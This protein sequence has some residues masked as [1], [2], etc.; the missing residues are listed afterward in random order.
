MYLWPLTV[1]V[2]VALSACVADV[3]TSDSSQPATVKPGG[4]SGNGD[5]CPKT[6]C[7]TNSPFLG[8][9]EFHE[10]EETGT[11]ANAEG[12]RV[13]RMEKLGVPY[14]PHVS[15]AV[16]TGLI[17][18]TTVLRG[19]ELVGAELI[20]LNDL[21]GEQFGIKIV[22]VSNDQTFWRP[23]DNGGLGHIETYELLWHPIGGTYKPVCNNPPGRSDPEGTKWNVTA[24]AILFTGDRYDADTLTVTATTIGGSLNWFNVGCSGNVMS[25]LF[26]NRHTNASQTPGFPTS[27]EQRQAMLKMYTSDLCGTGHA[28]T[29]QGTPLHW[30]SSPGWSSIAIDYP[31][32]EALWTSHGAVCLDTHRLHLSANDM[33]V[34]YTAACAAI[35]QTLPRCST[36]T[37]TATLASTGAYLRTSSPAPF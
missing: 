20:I 29:V 17:G 37:G 4:G 27:L 7:G 35:L 8:P 31:H 6:G 2:L 1:S 3:D 24:E 16:L 15:G 34:Q 36:S 28:F 18:R 23:D 14:R 13:L 22:H 11:S 12:F 10:L 25:K 9:I 32:Q 21:T 19:N 26:L 5:P 30:S 33:T